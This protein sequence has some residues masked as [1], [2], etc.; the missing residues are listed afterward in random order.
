M[1]GVLQSFEPLENLGENGLEFRVLFLRGVILLRESEVKGS[2]IDCTSIPFR[3][4][5]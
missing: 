2:N 1:M 4:A 5:H 3:A